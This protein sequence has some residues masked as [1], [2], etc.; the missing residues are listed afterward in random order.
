M[1][2]SPKRGKEVAD[3]QA[4]REGPAGHGDHLAVDQLV[5]QPIG[6]F[7]S[8]VLGVAGADAGGFG[9]LTLLVQS[10]PSSMRYTTPPP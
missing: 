7:Q 2:G 5:L 9:H 4:V 1:E 8:Q 6:L 10:Y 3:Q